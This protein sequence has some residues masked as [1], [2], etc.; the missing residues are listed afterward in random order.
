MM[1]TVATPQMAHFAYVPQPPV[2]QM[3]GMRMRAPVSKTSAPMNVRPHATQRPARMAPEP[4]PVRVLDRSLPRD[5]R[6]SGR[7]FV[8]LDGWC[9]SG[10]PGPSMGACRMSPSALL[11]GDGIRWVLVQG[12]SGCSVD[13]CGSDRRVT[14]AVR[15][16]RLRRAVLTVRR[17]PPGSDRPMQRRGRHRSPSEPG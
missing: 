10:F 16:G 2:A 1:V 15:L 6:C 5:G 7:G 14:G 12:R 3:S 9:L 11:S 17:R 4:P 8:R 13:G